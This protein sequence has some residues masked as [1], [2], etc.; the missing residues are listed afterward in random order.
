MAE[1]DTGVAG[2]WK[3][4]ALLGKFLGDYLRVFEVKDGSFF[5][6]G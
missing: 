5:K 2:L 6:R 4:R 3:R 1:L